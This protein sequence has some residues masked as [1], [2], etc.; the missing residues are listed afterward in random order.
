MVVDTDAI[1]SRPAR[2]LCIQWIPNAVNFHSTFS[3]VTRK[4]SSFIM[5]FQ[6][7]FLPHS[8]MLLT[9]SSLHWSHKLYFLLC[10]SFTITVCFSNENGY[11][12]ALISIINFLQHFYR[13][14]PISARTIVHT[15]YTFGKHWKSSDGRT[16]LIYRN[17]LKKKERKKSTDSSEIHFIEIYTRSIHGYSRHPN[18]STLER[19]KPISRPCNRKKTT[20]KNRAATRSERI[21]PKR[22]SFLWA[23]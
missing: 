18:D 8:I 12:Q 15:P 1:A 21:K 20:K 16:Q 23:H 19:T 2:P 17:E 10:H 5:H 4:R 9:P 7:G 6:Q 3:I 13:H 22:E 11:C 14:K